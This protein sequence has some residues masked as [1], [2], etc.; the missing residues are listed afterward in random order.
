[1]VCVVPST[2][3]F[4]WG[5]TELE[6][7]CLR[8]HLLLNYFAGI[9]MNSEPL[10]DRNSLGIPYLENIRFAWSTTVDERLSDI[11]LISKEFEL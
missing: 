8:S 5:W 11:S 10:R 2:C 3:P 6:V 1:M 9:P 7:V 4:D